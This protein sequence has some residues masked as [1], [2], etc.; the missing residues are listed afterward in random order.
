MWKCRQLSASDVYPHLPTTK[1]LAEVNLRFDVAIVGAGPAGCAAALALRN[2]GLRIAL[3]DKAAF[4]RDKVCGDAISPDVLKQLYWLDP[5]MAALFEKRFAQHRCPSASFVAPSGAHATVA[6]N[7]THL[8]GYVVPR[9]DFD[10]FLF[11]HAAALPE[12]EVITASATEVIKI[13]DSVSVKLEN[14]QTIGSELVI[15]A[16]GAQGITTRS[17]GLDVRNDEYFCAGLRQYW[18]GI[19]PDKR[20]NGIELHFNQALVPG[21]LWLFPLGDGRWNVGVGMMSAAVSK[22]KVNLRAAMDHILKTDQR[23][24]PRFAE[25]VPLE[26]PKGFGLP[27]AGIRRPLSAQ[28]ALLVGDAGSL[29]NPFSGEG[30]CNAV[31]SGRFAAQTALKA[32][33]DGDFS[34]ASLA[35]Y[36][37]RFYSATLSE[38]RLS[39]LFQRLMRHPLLANGVVRFALNNAWLQ[40]GL[41]N[42]FGSVKSQLPPWQ[43]SFE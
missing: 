40:R 3:I 42:G 21:Y 15:G 22:K 12:V 30:I 18:S 34:A 1:P 37:S 16:D 8:R 28:R 32:F 38:I 31:R 39:L 13:K 25:A 10:H 20:F 29:I 35:A 36:D 2:S 23:L 9:F 27:L 14:D 19:L 43:S 33:A 6:L 11:Q 41:V 26:S 17:L 7:N 5:V 4:P 24:A